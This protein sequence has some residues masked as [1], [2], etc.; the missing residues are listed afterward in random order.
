MTDLMGSYPIGAMQPSRQR[1]LVA[2]AFKDG[3]GCLGH[4]RPPVR[5]A[6]PQSFPRG[7]DA[8]KDSF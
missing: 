5:C 8:V 2:E 1:A 3:S 7:C 6:S 4:A